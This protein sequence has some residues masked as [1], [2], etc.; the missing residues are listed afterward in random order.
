MI[1]HVALLSALLPALLLLA[2]AAWLRLAGTDRAVFLA[3]NQALNTA[4]PATD[5]AWS[6]ASELGLATSGVLLLLTV[7]R[8]RDPASLRLA[9]ALLW[10]L[11][12][13]GLITHLPKRLLATPRP[14]AVLEP[15]SF[16]L[17]GEALTRH[18][19][20]SGHSLTAFTLA[21]LLALVM[22]PGTDGRMAAGAGAPVASRG[23]G[24]LLAAACF[25]LAGLVAL[26][27]VAVAA[28]WPSDISAGAGLG[29][30]AG[31]AAV[32]LADR[33]GG[34]FARWLGGRRGQLALTLLT[35]VLAAFF[36]RD[37]LIGRGD[38]PLARPLD[39]L[40]AGLGLVG[41]VLRW[42]SLPADGEAAR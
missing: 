6:W 20:P 14:P 42:R 35:A 31:L 39:L 38:Y 33:D 3:L 8:G 16:H 37:L 4:A 13:G 18:S 36:V 17:I 2:L 28:H 30:L 29:L 19:L 10:S 1:G 25:A 22:V 12:V 24:W 11:P 32:A 34:R 7:W 41:A 9:A 21:T 27:R 23:R 15:G 26:S 40:L 5:L